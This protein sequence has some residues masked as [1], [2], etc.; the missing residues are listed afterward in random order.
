[1]N[2]RPVGLL[3]P[4]FLAV[5]ALSAGCG[6]DDNASNRQSQVREAGAAVMPFDLDETKHSFVKTSDGGVQTVVALDSQDTEQVGL[7]R[8][9]LADIRTEFAEGRFDDPNTIHGPDMPGIAELAAGAGRLDISYRDVGGG[10][11]ITY[12]TDDAALVGALHDWFDAQVS[13]HGHDATTEPFDH[14]MTEEMW[15]QHHPGQPYPD[16]S[17]GN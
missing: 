3:G 1:M 2:R 15:R 14:T 12:R 6:A 4:V 13:D 17:D 5:A 9:H 8:E 7:V 10:G 11:E 16:T